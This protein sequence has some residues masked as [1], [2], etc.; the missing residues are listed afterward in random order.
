[1]FDDFNQTPA[2]QLAKRAGFQNADGIADLRL[3]LLIV[4]VE[5]LAVLYDLAEAGMRDAGDGLDD[6][7]L[8]HLGGDDTADTFLAQATLVGGHLLNWSF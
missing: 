2:L 3:V 1:V 5:A 4:H 6:A 8:V 7:R